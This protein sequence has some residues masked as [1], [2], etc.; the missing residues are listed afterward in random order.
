MT[1][2]AQFPFFLS[3]K[4]QSRK[5]NELRAQLVGKRSD[6]LEGYVIEIDD[7]VDLQNLKIRYRANGRIVEGVTFQ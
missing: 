6:T 4:Y 5:L 7:V 3:Q 2:G 1:L